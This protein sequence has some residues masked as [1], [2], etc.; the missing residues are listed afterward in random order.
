MKHV[1]KKQ[2]NKLA[3]AFFGRELVAIASPQVLPSPWKHRFHPAVEGSAWE[4]RVGI[5]LVSRNGK[6]L[7]LFS[8]TALQLKEI[9]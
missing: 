4:Q 2:N 7:A 8:R 6:V 3:Q 9:S 5:W 1:K